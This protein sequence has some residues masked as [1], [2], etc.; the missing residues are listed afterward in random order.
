M[1]SMKMKHTFALILNQLK[2]VEN[3]EHQSV[4]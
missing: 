1:K 3:P 4:N 2:F